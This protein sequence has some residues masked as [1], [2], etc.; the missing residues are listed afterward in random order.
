MSY[1]TSWNQ[2]TGFTLQ[3]GPFNVGL[4]APANATLYT[5][6]GPL[7]RTQLVGWEGG[8]N[9]SADNPSPQPSP[10]PCRSIPLPPVCL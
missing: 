6:S 3:T 9:N 7:W 2:V 8:A 5:G 1:A 4:G 10:D